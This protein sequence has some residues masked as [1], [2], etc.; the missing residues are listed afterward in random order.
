MVGNASC[1]LQK[2]TRSHSNSLYSLSFNLSDFVKALMTF[3]IC[4]NFGRFIY[5]FGGYQKIKERTPENMN[6]MTIANLKKENKNIIAMPGTF[7]R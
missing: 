7:E 4:S 1:T 6:K 3:M 2:E 5:T